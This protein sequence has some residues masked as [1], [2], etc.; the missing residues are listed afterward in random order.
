MDSYD[1][2]D[3][4]K[5]RKHKSKKRE[6]RGD[7]NDR[8]KHKKR[9]EKE[10]VVRVVDDDLD[11]EDMW[12]EKNIDKDGEKASKVHV[13][14]M[15]LSHGPTKPIAADI[16]TAESLKLTS[17]AQS[18]PHDPSL[19]R[20]VVAESSLKRDDWMLE[21]S[22]SSAA[23]PMMSR[24]QL[25]GGDESLTDGYGEPSA[26]SRN[27]GGEIDF[28]SNLGKEKKRKPKPDLPNPDKVTP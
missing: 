21:P 4:H 28:F 26:S 23:P 6:H 27:F 1:L 14:G 22:T 2:N 9:K 16:P 18:E 3:K 17:H 12:V 25:D 10:A 8:R 11:G 13:F 7:S 5:D 20:A 15:A 19:P 24:P